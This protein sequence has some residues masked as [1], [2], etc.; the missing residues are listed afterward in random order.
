MSG[1]NEYAQIRLLLSI[2]FLTF[3]LITLPVNGKLKREIAYYG[4]VCSTLL[5]IKSTGKAPASG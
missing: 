3:Q 1:F 5:P 4:P 2:F